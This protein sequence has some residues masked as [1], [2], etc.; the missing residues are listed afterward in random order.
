M[1]LAVTV[2]GWNVLTID[3]STPATE[4]VEVDGGY[5]TATPISFVSAHEL[6]D[7]SGLPYRE[8]WE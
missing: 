7:G 8:G 6:P 2:F 5:L 1:Q 3:L 4:D